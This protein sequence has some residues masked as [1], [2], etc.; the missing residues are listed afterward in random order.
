MKLKLTLRLEVVPE[1]SEIEQHNRWHRLIWN[2]G[3]ALVKELMDRGTPDELAGRPACHC[4]STT[5]SPA[6]SCRVFVALPIKGCP[7][8]EKFVASLLSVSLA[9][10]NVEKVSYLKPT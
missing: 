10:P 1:G 3:K 6:G 4:G 8:H 5:S 9:S 2:H 7:T